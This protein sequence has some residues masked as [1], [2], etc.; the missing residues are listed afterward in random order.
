[1]VQLKQGVHFLSKTREGKTRDTEGEGA[2]V[3]HLVS[4]TAEIKVRRHEPLVR[5]A[6]DHDEARILVRSRGERTSLPR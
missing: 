5:A 4:I 2:I 1:M 6:P 3:L